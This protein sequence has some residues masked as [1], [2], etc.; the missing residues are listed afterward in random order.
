MGFYQDRI[1]PRLINA[2][3]G[4][5][6]IARERARIVPEAEGVVLDVGFGS[7]TNLG[8]YDPAR[9]RHVIGLDPSGAMLA[10]SSARA[11][12]TSIPY[13]IV[14]A[15]AEAMPIDSA[16][17][18]S[19]VM[20]FTLCTIRETL[21]ALSECRRVLKPGGRLLFLEHGRAQRDGARWV[22]DRL[23][24]VW[25][26]IAGGCHLNR[27]PLAEFDAAGFAIE[28]RDVYTMRGAPAFV[29]TLYRGRAR[30]G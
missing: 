29:G 16:T 19:V 14:E 6:Q 27:D 25:K 12:D 3:C 28:D 21:A 7:G 23:T 26:P 9:V 22:Q 1:L 11:G 5:P 13:E 20:T 17:I 18:D 15:G 24:P 2:A 4:A 10:K 8:H 30:P